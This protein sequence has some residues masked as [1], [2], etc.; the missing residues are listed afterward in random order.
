M[1]QGRGNIEDFL[2]RKLGNLENQFSGDWDT[3]E[4]KLER[5]LFVRQLRRMAFF[6]GFTVL[7]TAAFIATNYYNIGLQ[8]EPYQEV[9]YYEPRQ[10]QQ[11][12]GAEAKVLQASSLAVNLVSNSQPAVSAPLSSEEPVSSQDRAVAEGS[13]TG[14]APID[15]TTEVVAIINNDG[16][17]EIGLIEEQQSFVQLNARSLEPVFF[18]ASQQRVRQNQNPFRLSDELSVEGLNSDYGF[19]TPRMAL[20]G[21]IPILKIEKEDVGPYVSP[22]QEEN[23]M[24]Y[25]LNVYPNFTFRKFKVDEDKARFMHR[26]FIDAVEV[27]ESGGF[28]L[29][30]GLEISRRVGDITYINTGIE[31]ISN[32]VQADFNFT[33]FRTA[34]IDQETGEIL[35]YSLKEQEEQIVF[36]DKNVYQY[37]NFPLS[38]SYQP[39]ANDHIRL[40]M[41]IGGSYLYFLS[42]RGGS[43]DYK[44]LDRID[45][46]EREYRNSIGSFSFKVGANYFVT[47]RLNIGFE[48]TLMYFTN[49]IYTEDNPFYVIPYSVGL[50]FN[51]QIKLN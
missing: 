50:N 32:T 22:L 18:Q 4:Q 34:N 3:F 24:S 8:G 44:T 6:G 13:I 37:L 47:K 5:A 36:S 10:D 48:P 29:N 42:A 31:F 49:T 16:D 35:D 28:S 30:V 12:F 23:P 9:S 33:N 21:P 1:N 40:N 19:I 38:I 51:L 27:A 2:R 45:I 15:Q 7:L 46:S 17:I 41:E 20:R 26:D 39:W 43:L 14:E 11:I 25:S